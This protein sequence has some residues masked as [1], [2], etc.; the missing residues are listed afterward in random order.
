MLDCGLIL[1]D[2]YIEFS[3]ISC[4]KG[5]QESFFD[6]DKEKFV[7][8]I[9]FNNSNKNKYSVKKMNLDI[10]LT[11]YMSEYNIGKP[12]TYGYHSK[13]VSSYFDKDWKLNGLGRN[14]LRLANKISRKLLDKNTV[15]ETEKI[16]EDRNLDFLDKIKKC[17]NIYEINIK[18]IGL[19]YNK[20]KSFENNFDNKE[21]SNNNRNGEFN[22]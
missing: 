22:I 3:S 9:F 14:G 12:S 5:I 16:L 7:T 6:E 18:N 11:K 13:N 21:N 2:S 20:P 4:K 10:M 15:Y 1:K 17:L 19:N 8:K